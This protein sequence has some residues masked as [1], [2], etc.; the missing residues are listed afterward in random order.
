MSKA[1]H[2]PVGGITI[3]VSICKDDVSNPLSSCTKKYS[4]VPGM[5]CLLKNLK[6]LGW[7]ENVS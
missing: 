1:I 5:V 4:K 7:P 2:L 3:Q 6:Q